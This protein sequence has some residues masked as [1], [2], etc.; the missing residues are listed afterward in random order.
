MSWLTNPWNEVECSTDTLRSINLLFQCGNLYLLYTLICKLHHPEKVP[1]NKK[2]IKIRRKTMRFPSQVLVFVPSHAFF[3]CLFLQTH[4][5]SRRILSAFSLSSFPLLYFFNFLY[6]TEVGSAFFTLFAY[7]MTLHGWH[8]TSASLG[9]CAILFRQTNVVWVAFCAATVV[10]ARMDEAWRAEHT[11]KRDEGP[12]PAQAPPS[13]ADGKRALLFVRDFLSLPAHV[14]AVALL[15]WPYA[16]VCAGFLVFVAINGSI[17]VGDHGNH[18]AVL[19][20]PQVFYF[21]SFALVFSLPV[22][23]CH[24]RVQRFLRALRRQPL[25]F[26]LLAAASLLLVWKLTYEHEYMLKDTRHYTNMVWCRLMKPYELVRLAF[27]PV[28]VFAAW[29]FV[30]SLESH[31]FFWCL[32]ILVSVLLATAFQKL[33]EFRYFIIPYLMYRLHMPLTSLPRLALELLLYTAVNVATLYIFIDET[34][35]SRRLMW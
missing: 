32:A 27:V 35:P 13:L 24:Q 11:K 14:K 7:L 18:V 8:R 33:L 10:V 31:S 2:K 1:F 23:L 19:H 9:V 20:I 3:W 15:V 22:S 30:D 29:S 28:Y 34:D 4:M 6:Y 16:V 21:F 12:A 26:L 17:V 25:L 5:T